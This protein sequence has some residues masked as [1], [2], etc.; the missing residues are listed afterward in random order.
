M[1]EV[2][3]RDARIAE[4]EAMVAALLK[5]VAELEARLNQNSSNSSKPPSSDPPGTGRTTKAPTG[6][7]PG[8][9]SGHKHHKRELMP[10]E[11]VNKVVELVPGRCG[12]CKATLKGRDENPERHQTVELPP[13]TPFVTEYR[14]HALTCTCGITTRAELPSEAMHVFG[15][16]LTALIAL[17]SG[18]YRLSK[19]LVQCILSNVLGV[20]LALGTVSNRDMEVSASLAAPMAEA[21][22]A[23]RETDGAHMDETGWFEGKV[24][25]RSKRAWLWVA[26]TGY[27]TVFRIATSRGSEVAKAMLGDN[28]TGFLTTDRWSAYN[29]FHLAL[30]QLCW[31]HLTRD[32]QSFIDRGGESERIGALLMDDRNR[33]FRWWRRVRDGTL[34]REEFE[35][36]MRRVRRRVGRLLRE[37]VVCPD[38][39]T[40]GMAK[41][42]LKLEEAMWTFVDDPRL[43]PTNNI[44]ERTIRHA[45]M[46]RKT[47]FGTQS[48]EGSRFV[49][50]ILTTV[51]T[52]KQQNRNVLEFLT[53]AVHAYRCHITPPSLLPGGFGDQLALAA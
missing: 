7:K 37:A 43:E 3:P 21:E 4:L 36:R 26:V 48:P 9:Q 52:L 25:G 12:G 39:K 19:R 16:R 51:A 53:E 47:S 15:E 30:R 38:A 28:Y 44:A 46:Y 10:V 32:W 29:W 24:N 8:G 41:E 34:E 18:Q 42:V 50:R 17:L 14:S 20:D 23:A 27:V 45:V 22:K 49:E 33:M 13:I 1:P 5:R 11:R 35:R 2:D 31:S 40:A 6:R